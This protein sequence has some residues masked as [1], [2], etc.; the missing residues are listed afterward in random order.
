M[1]ADS[2]ASLRWSYFS[3]QWEENS[4]KWTAPRMRMKKTYFSKSKIL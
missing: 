1:S 3:H 2:P 4:D